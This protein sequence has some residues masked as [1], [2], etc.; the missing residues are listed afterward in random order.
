M[1]KPEVRDGKTIGHSFEDDNAK[2]F[3]GT[4]ELG[5]D[6]LSPYFPDYRFA[7]LKQVHGK[8]VIEADAAQMLEADAHFTSQP[9]IALV[10]QTADCVPILLANHERVCAIHSGWKGCAQNI[11]E[12][13]K[14]AFPSLPPRRAAI[15]PHILKTS[16]EIGV[17]V[18][19]QL[20]AAVPK[21]FGTD[22]LKLPH[23]DP[24]KAYFDLTELVRRQIRAAFGPID[25]VEHLSDTVTDKDLNSFRRD[26][27]HAGRNY[28]FV[29]LK[30]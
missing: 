13:A 29:V 7:F 24:A 16:F 2:F 19:A 1:F 6:N 4:R 5:K 25:I 12:A 23:P 26:K 15:G 30:P 10:S 22:G 11:V 8:A 3:F 28:S 17:D 20:L 21:G 18:S 27:A 14:R 9:G